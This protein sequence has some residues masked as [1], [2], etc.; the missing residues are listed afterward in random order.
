M[1]LAIAFMDFFTCF[2]HCD[3]S[4]LCRQ[5]EQL[6]AQVSIPRCYDTNFSPAGVSQ[7]LQRGTVFSFLDVRTSNKLGTTWKSWSFSFWI[8]LV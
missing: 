6:L 1:L 3:T 4:L 7:T 8:Y 5:G 2:P